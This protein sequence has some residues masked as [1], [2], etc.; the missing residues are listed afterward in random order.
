MKIRR[1]QTVLKNSAMRAP[2]R[3]PPHGGHNRDWVDVTGARTCRHKS[4]LSLVHGQEQF[5]SK[6]EHR[7]NENSP[8]P[9]RAQEQCDAGSQQR[10]QKHGNAENYAQLQIHDTAPNEYYCRN[11]RRK[12]VD[13]LAVATTKVNKLFSSN[14]TVATPEENTLITLVVATA[15]RKVMPKNRTKAAV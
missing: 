1:S 11:A 8:Q 13:H 7:R 5:D 2:D 6:A 4:E 9:D 3:R 12:H 10:T 15:R 14:I